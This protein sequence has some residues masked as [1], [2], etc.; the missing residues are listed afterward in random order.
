MKNIG[1][2][3][4]TAR[5]YNLAEKIA[6]SLKNTCSVD[7]FE[8]EKESAREYLEE[9]FNKKDTFLFICA[10]GIAVRLIAP[11]I[12][13][14]DQDPAVVV[15][16]EFGRFSIPLLS[17]HLGGANEAAAEF[18]KITEAELVLTT[19]TDINGQFAV[20][21]WSK[22]AG[23]HIM[24]ISKI[25]LV[26]SAVLREEKVGISSGFPFEGEMPAPLTLDEAETGIC[27]SLAGNQNTYQNT[28]N[29]VPRIVTVGVGCRKG[30]SAEVFEKFILK[31]LS[32][33]NIA[34]QAVERI[35]SIE[36]KKYEPCILSFCDKYKIPFVTFTAEELQS[37]KGD[38]LSSD[39]VKTVTGTDNVCERS[40]VLASSYGTRILS[41][42]SG[43]GCT[44][45][46]AM[47]DWKCKF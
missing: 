28:L 40:A 32:Q 19:A 24:D 2:V 7:V 27:V 29:L 38:F 21:V 26:S 46:L 13:S 5:G 15:M 35:A 20:D 37:V 6:E 25:K 1:I 23:C 22:Y 44:C 47:R 45:A 43:N 30:V 31:Q 12:K 14:K 33:K 16:D 9:S 34:I 4:F 42:T 11:L 41:K 39:L 18:A 3:A 36:L 8:K 17:G 10:A